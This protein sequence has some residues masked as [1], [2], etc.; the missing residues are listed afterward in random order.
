MPADRTL[1]PAVL[2]PAGVALLLFA[3]AFVRLRRRGRRDHASWFRA[4]L[5]LGAVTA[6]TLG[7]G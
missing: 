3:S 1:A 7:G 5:F 6:L 4:A 2:A